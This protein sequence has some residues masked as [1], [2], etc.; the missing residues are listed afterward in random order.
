MYNNSQQSRLRIMRVI[1]FYDLPSDS[2]R[3]RKIYSF[4]HGFLI[5]NGFYM[6]QESIYG[7]LARNH[8][9]ARLTINKV[10]ANSPAEGDVRCLLITEQQYQNIHIFSGSVSSQEKIHSLQPLVEI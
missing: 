4:F 2:E 1:L 8:D 3:A 6:I 10:K 7:C 9:F 5:K